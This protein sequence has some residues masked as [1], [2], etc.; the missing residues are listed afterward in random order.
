[1]NLMAYNLDAESKHV[2][3]HFS[4]SERHPSDTAERLRGKKKEKIRKKSQEP[5]LS[6][7]LD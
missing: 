6:F 5:H 1:M 3:I 7:K 4:P 2:T